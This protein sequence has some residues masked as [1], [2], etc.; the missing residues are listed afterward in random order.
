MKLL[1]AVPSKGRAKE[2]EK[3]T[4]S[5]LQYTRFDWNVFIEPG[6]YD[7]Y[8]KVVRHPKFLVTIPENNRGLG[9]CKTQIKKYAEERGYDLVFKVDDD[10]L[11]WRDPM[12]RGLGHNAPKTTKEYKCKYLFDVLIKDSL[13]LFKAYP[14]CGGVSIMY[15]Q[16][17]KTFSGETWIGINNR[18][19][20]N[21]IVLIKLLAPPGSSLNIV[22]EDFNT[23][24]NLRKRGYYTVRYGLTGADVRPVGINEGGWQSFDR[25]KLAERAKDFLSKI[26]KGLVWKR[27]EGKKWQWE[28][29]FRKTNFDDL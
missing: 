6:E 13:K 9:Y 17:M 12:N 2:F 29:D 21:Y 22:F 27:V 16:D 19:Q 18:L 1:I 25:G 7:D 26:Y 14:E 20:T 28:P 3:D 11:S 24:L 4:Y 10:V 5:W 8:I 15:G 23:Y